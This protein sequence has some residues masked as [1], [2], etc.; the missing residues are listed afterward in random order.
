MKDTKVPSR[1][2][3]AVRGRIKWDEKVPKNKIARNKIWAVG[4]QFLA[5]YS[6]IE[7]EAKTKAEAY[8]KAYGRSPFDSQIESIKE[9]KK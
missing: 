1:A 4:I 7:V 2:N 9:I 6:T 8:R 5:Q 3:A